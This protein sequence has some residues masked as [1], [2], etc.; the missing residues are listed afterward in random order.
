VVLRKEGCG[1][2]D[3]IVNLKIED[4]DPARLHIVK[5][6]NFERHDGAAAYW[7]VKMVFAS[8]TS[9]LSKSSAAYSLEENTSAGLLEEG[10]LENRGL[11]FVCL[12]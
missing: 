11:L 8:I 2:D 1:I 7:G 3:D 9:L 6:G 12:S 10:V 4:A 5:R